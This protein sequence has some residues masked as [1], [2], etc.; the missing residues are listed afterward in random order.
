MTLRASDAEATALG[1]AA[2]AGAAFKQHEKSCNTCHQ[3]RLAHRAESS[4][5]EGYEMLRTG[6]RAESL[7]RQIRADK[8]QRKALQRGL[9]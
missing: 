5:D 8:K 2:A 1:A 9:F 6:A 7:I 3:A 4:C